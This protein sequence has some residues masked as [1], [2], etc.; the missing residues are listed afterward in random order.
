MNQVINGVELKVN[1]LWKTKSGNNVLTVWNGEH[2]KELRDPDNHSPGANKISFIWFDETDNELCVAEPLDRLET[3]IGT[4]N[5]KRIL[6]YALKAR[7]IEGE[8]RLNYNTDRLR[9]LYNAIENLVL[10]G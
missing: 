4:I 10:L 3:Y 6:E 8:L 5:P 1:Q 7:R 2:E 9:E